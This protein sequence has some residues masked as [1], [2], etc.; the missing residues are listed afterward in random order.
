MS[1]P[2]TGPDVLQAEVL[3]H[4]L[5]GDDVLQAL[6][7]PVQRVV[8]RAT[9]DRGAMQGLLAPGQEPLVAAG[10]PQRRQVLGQAALGLAVRPLVV[11]DHDDQR[12]VLVGG[13]RVERLPGHAAGQRAVAD[14]GH[15][16]PVP[17]AGEPARLGD[18]VGP[19]QRGGRVRVLDHVVP[20]LG[21]ARD[22]RTGH[23][24][25]A[26]RR[27]PAGRS[28]ACARRTGGRC[29]RPPC[30]GASRRPG[31]SRGSARPRPRLGPRWPPVR[32]TSAIRKPRI[33]PASSSS[34]AAVS[35][36]RSLGAWIVS[37][38][39][40]GRRLLV[41]RS[42]RRGTP[43]A[44]QAESK[45]GPFTAAAR[46]DARGAL[47]PPD[48]HLARPRPGAP[49]PGRGRPA[50]RPA[51][52]A[53]SASAS[54]RRARGQRRPRAGLLGRDVMAHDDGQRHRVPGQHRRSRG[55]PAGARSSSQATAER[56]QPGTPGGRTGPASQ[57][58]RPRQPTA[59][60]RRG[61]A[62]RTAGS[63]RCGSS[64]PHPGC[65]SAPAR[66]TR[67]VRRP[68]ASP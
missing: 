31:G 10:R 40:I 8:H 61:N 67:P 16:V 50:A 22:S 25:R 46:N 54:S 11:V 13:D 21:P 66:R 56:S 68:R 47:P 19:G 62:A 9:D 36:R 23:P 33:S 48:P 58:A 39:P 27:S 55:S 7:D 52:A 29:R 37:S 64:R 60:P 24:A 12:Q 6:L 57:P 51:P 30:R 41:V 42:P 63:R 28:P 3:E 17:L 59:R 35:E 38:R 18:A 5:R 15:G 26:G 43:A 65:R 34:C 49:P 44:R 4:A 53:A 32:V 1:W 20:A 2:S 45:P 14:D